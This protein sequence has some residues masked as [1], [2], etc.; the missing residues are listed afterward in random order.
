VLADVGLGD[1]EAVNETGDVAFALMQ[2]DAK[3][4]EAVG[5]AEDPEPGGYRVKHPRRKNFA[6]AVRISPYGYIRKYSCVDGK[7]V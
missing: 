7:E 2:E 3:D 6:H 1:A 5:I 4:G